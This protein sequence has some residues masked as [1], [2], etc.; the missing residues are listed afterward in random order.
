MTPWEA[1]HARQRLEKRDLLMIVLRECEGSRTAA[2]QRLGLRRTYLLRLIREF[3][4]EHRVPKGAT[5]VAGKERTDKIRAR[6][7]LVKDVA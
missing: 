1:L 7:G 2:A 5:G 3:E 4:I 6:F